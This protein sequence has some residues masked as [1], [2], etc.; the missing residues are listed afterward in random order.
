MLPFAA[1]HALSVSFRG[2]CFGVRALVCTNAPQIGP[3]Y[4]PKFARIALQGNLLGGTLRGTAEL[5]DPED[6][7]DAKPRLQLD[8]QLDRE[9]RKRG[10]TVIGGGYSAATD[11]LWCD[12]NVAVFGKTTIVM[13][14]KSLDAPREHAH[15]P[16]WA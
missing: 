1:L 12:M 11:V 5:V 16:T 9:L 2:G 14:R 13:H 4:S 15:D 10:V 3:V 8:P 7:A 6:G